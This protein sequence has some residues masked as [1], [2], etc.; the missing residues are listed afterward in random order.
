[1]LIHG[2]KFL[3]YK[4][5]HWVLF[6]DKILLTV[7][8]IKYCRFADKESTR[9]HSCAGLWLFVKSRSYSVGI[10]LK[11]TEPSWWSNAERWTALIA[12]EITRKTS[13]TASEVPT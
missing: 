6:E 7:H 10:N 11:F 2:E 5:L 12:P 4:R 8:V 1:M 9:N 3:T 13:H